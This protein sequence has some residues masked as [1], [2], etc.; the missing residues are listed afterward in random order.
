[1][2]EGIKTEH[3]F[4]SQSKPT[5]MIV[6]ADGDIIRNDIQGYGQNM[7]VLPL[8]YDRY[9]NQQFGNSDFILNAVNYLTDDDGWMELRSREIKLRLLNRPAVIGQRTFWQMI[10][11]LLPLF[12][13]AVF[14]AL[15][16]LIRK[17]KYTSSLK[18]SVQKE[19][20]DSVEIKE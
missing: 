11:V 17:R 1:M 9:M 3:K 7:N 12:F 5:K 18:Y 10:N 6:V 2:P 19:E 20:K 8:G 13:L 4:L 15:F 14:A 16:L